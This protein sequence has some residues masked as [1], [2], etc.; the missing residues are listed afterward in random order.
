S[1][2]FFDASM[3]EALVG[4]VTME[5]DLRRALDD[6]EFWVAYQPIVALESHEVLGIEALLRWEHPTKGNIPPNDFIA[7]AEETGLILRIG[8][9]VLREACQRTA[10]WNAQRQDGKAFSVTVNLSVRQLES[11]TLV[12]DVE[13]ALGTAGLSPSLLVLEITE[14][15]LM[16]RTESTLERLHELKQIG[17]R[18][19]IDD[20]GTG[21]S[22]LSYLQQFPVDILKIDRS[23]TD[24]LMRG[25]HD[26]ALARTIIALG[27]LLTLRTIAEGVEHA[28]QHARLRDLGCDYGQGY[29]FSRPLAPADVDLLLRSGVLELPGEE[30]IVLTVGGAGGAAADALDDGDGAGP[31]PDL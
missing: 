13:E 5:G 23:F 11:P 21:Y 29:L 3:H 28:R 17:V 20:F 25:S 7:L 4:R 6:G 26:D 10:Q 16:H 12:S 8:G 14:N 9:W 1:H 2:V 15:A 31:P 27:D 18:L 30:P 22:S 19:A 24:G